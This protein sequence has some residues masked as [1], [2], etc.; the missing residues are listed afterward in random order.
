ML[1]FA[2]RCFCT[3][4]AI[5]SYQPFPVH[6]H[7][8]R[9]G[10]LTADA[11]CAFEPRR[12]R[13]AQRDGRSGPKK[14]RWRFQGEESR[15]SVPLSGWGGSVVQRPLQRGLTGEQQA[16]LYVVS[17]AAATGSPAHRIDSPSALETL[18]GPPPLPQ[19]PGGAN[20]GEVA[21]LACTS[22]PA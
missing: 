4:I 10:F 17:I 12:R 1:S 19:Q 7:C 13:T 9:E 2:T 5:W 20:A 8:T 21:C 11:S 14:H 6:C 22:F 15:S 18:T 16:T 3:Q